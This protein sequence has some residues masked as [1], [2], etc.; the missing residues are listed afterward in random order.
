MS[1]SFYPLQR[2][3]GGVID[4]A[5]QPVP[6]PCDHLHGEASPNGPSAVPDSCARCWRPVL[7]H[8]CRTAPRPPRVL[9]S[10]WPLTTSSPQPRERQSPLLCPTTN[11]SHKLPSVFTCMYSLPPRTRFGSL[12]VCRWIQL[13]VV[14]PV[15]RSRPRPPALQTT[16]RGMDDRPAPRDARPASPPPCVCSLSIL[17]CLFSCLFSHLNFG[18]LFL[19]PIQIPVDPAP[20]SSIRT[21]PPRSAPG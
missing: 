3:V 15:S 18:S 12:F 2:S 17:G 16:S 9:A 13:G 19:S 21:A 5:A 6:A 14:Q 10:P 20:A 7:G 8:V 1:P 11:F 4:S